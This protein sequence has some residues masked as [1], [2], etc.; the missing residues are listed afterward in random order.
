MSN[1]K[2]IDFTGL[3]LLNIIKSKVWLTNLVTEKLIY[4]SIF[5]KRVICKELAISK[6]L[7]HYVPTI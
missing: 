3:K 6:Y 1:N 7:Y 5:V 4:F 2:W